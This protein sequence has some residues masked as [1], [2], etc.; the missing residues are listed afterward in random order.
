[1]DNGASS[2]RRYLDGEESA[3]D[4]LL[5]L[6]FDRLVF[7]INKYVH[8]LADAEDLAI[9]SM[10]ELIIHP[11]RY[12]FKV[13]LKTYLFTIGRNKALNFIKHRNKLDF[14]DFSEAELSTEDYISLEDSIIA[15]EMQK[16][17]NR[18]VNDLPQDMG[19]AVFLVYIEGL[20]YEETAKI[21]KKNKKQIDNLLYRGKAELRSVI[22]KEGELLL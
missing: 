9:D 2:Y 18:A 7:F 1:M 12:N 3:F 16:T 8:N 21:M 11:K 22:G 19:M 15:S 6:Y 17:V 4:D 14:T 20:S 5:K 13:S 10:L